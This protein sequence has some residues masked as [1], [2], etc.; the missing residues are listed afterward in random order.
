MKTW[1]LKTKKMFFKNLMKVND[2]L[3]NNEIFYY[4]SSIDKNYVFLSFPLLILHSILFIKRLIC[5]L[6]TCPADVIISGNYKSSAILR[7]ENKTS[8]FIPS[9]IDY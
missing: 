4:D 6:L 5:F 8:V 2:Q 7:I 3:V 9:Y 1:L